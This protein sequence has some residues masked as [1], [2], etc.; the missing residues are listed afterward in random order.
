MYSEKN[1]L[2]NYNVGVVV[3]NSGDHPTTTDFTT[4]YN[5]RVFT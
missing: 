2:A 4:R 1:A 3:V 5:A